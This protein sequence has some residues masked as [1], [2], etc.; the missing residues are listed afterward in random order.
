MILARAPKPYSMRESQDKVSSLEF[1]EQTQNLRL[2]TRNPRSLSLTP[3]RF[4]SSL[5]FQITQIA[6]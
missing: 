6:G 5:S 3:H 4:L 1:R 2:E